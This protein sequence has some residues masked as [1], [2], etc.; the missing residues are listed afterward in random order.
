MKISQEAVTDAF[1][2]KSYGD[3]FLLIQTANQQQQR[4]THNCTLSPDGIFDML[5]LKRFVEKQ[6]NSF[7]EKIKSFKA[8]V[9]LLVN[10]EGITPNTLKLTAKLVEHGLS[11]EVMSLG[12]ACRTYNM[13]VNEGRKPIVLI[14]F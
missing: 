14:S 6:D 2:I 3:G 5:D 12:A 8:D 9:I 4:I 10:N 13:L 7:L 1:I 11:L